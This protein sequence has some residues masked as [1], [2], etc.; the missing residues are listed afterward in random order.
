[1]PTDPLTILAMKTANALANLMSVARN[2]INAKMAT[3]R[4]RIAINVRLIITVSQLV[5]LANV[6]NKD[7]NLLL[8]T[9]MVN[10]LARKMYLEPSAI[11]APMDLADF[12][13][14]KVFLIFFKRADDLQVF[15]L[16]RVRLQR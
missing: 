16:I 2:A 9:K 4:F 8:A 11:T 5:K 10:V 6:T 7:Q 1:M 13:H 14:L 15:Y 12:P 3:Q